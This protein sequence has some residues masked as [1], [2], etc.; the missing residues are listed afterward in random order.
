MGAWGTGSFEN[1]DGLDWIGEFC[2]GP[3]VGA[4][5]S[6]LETAAD[7]EGYLESP[8]AANALAAAEVVAALNRSPTTDIVVVADYLS[9]IARSGITVTPNLRAL[10]LR[11]VDRVAADSE[12]K[13]LWDEVEDSEQ[14]YAG[15]AALRARLGV[16]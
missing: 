4:L 8:D 1:D 6:T 14:W 2:D 16:A 15:V 10:A 3:T 12:L 11:A 7:A 5:R 13:E 9:V